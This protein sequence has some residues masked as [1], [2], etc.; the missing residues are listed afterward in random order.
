MNVNQTTL[1]SLPGPKSNL[2]VASATILW[3]PLM[4]TTLGPQLEKVSGKPKGILDHIFMVFVD[5]DP[6]SHSMPLNVLS[7]YPM[8]NSS[9]LV[10]P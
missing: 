9:I 4:C 5:L 6:L 1:S 7:L 8:V 10:M 3:M 2:E